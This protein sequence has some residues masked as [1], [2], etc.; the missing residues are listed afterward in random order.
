[1]RS[2][3]LAQ[4]PV[5]VVVERRKA[6]AC[7]LIFCGDRSRCLSEFLSRALDVL[8]RSRSDLVLQVKAIE[9]HRRNNKLSDTRIGRA[10]IVGRVPR[11]I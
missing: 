6:R 9:L 5:S 7:G 4:I 1:M 8:I 2:T 3:A 11:C 10:R